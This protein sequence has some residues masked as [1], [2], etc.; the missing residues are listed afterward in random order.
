M[1]SKLDT[2]RGFRRAPV[3][4]FGDQPAPSCA[5]GPLRFDWFRPHP[6]EGP[7]DRPSPKKFR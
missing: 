2:E 6:V 7:V 1:A 5:Q 3:L 4:A